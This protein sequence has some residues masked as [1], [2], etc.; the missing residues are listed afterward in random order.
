M[1]LFV[2]A[3][4]T[5]VLA[6]NLV[7]LYVGWEGVGLCSFLL[8]G[9]WYR[10]P[11]T[12]RAARKAFVV[13]R[14]GDAALV[15][16]L[17]LLFASLG[18]LDIVALTFAAGT[19][20]TAGEALP[21]AAAAL[22]LAGAVGKSAQLPLQVWLPDAMAGP[23][24]VSAL[25]HAA[26]MVTAGVY[27]IARMHGLFEL[28]PPVQAAVAIIG[29]LTLLLAAMSALAQTDLKRILAFST[30][31]QIGYMVMALG[32]GAYGAAVFHLTTHAYFKALLFLAAGVVIRR[33]HEEHD[34]R[35]MGG[36]AGALPATFACFAVG[37]AS[38]AALPLVTAGAYSK[39]LILAQVWGASGGAFLWLAGAVGAFLTALYIFRAVFLV[40]LGPQQMAPAGTTPAV[41]LAPMAVLAALAIFGG[42]I[43]VPA[44]V[45]G[46]LPAAEGHAPWPFAAI[47]AALPLAGIYVAWI[48]FHRRRG[49]LAELREAPATARLLGVW[50]VGFGFDQLYNKVA[51]RPFLWAARVNRGDAADRIATGAAALGTAGNRALAWTQSGRLRWYAGAL[52]CGM[53]LVLIAGVFA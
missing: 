26:T 21:V 15:L 34:I 29:A 20:W 37:A 31:S 50:Q 12:A 32:A 52:A 19:Q 23:S 48:V 17:V 42:T 11:G 6:D 30:I 45:A 49:A 22:L 44:F 5:L 2:A 27:L 3:M 39:E 46:A 36:L 40:F 43:P 10:D 47:A 9:F 38:L 4:L 33:L 35:K 7:L 16:G 41:M 8:I 51:A 13:T 28:A 24:P 25:I 1:N 14:V 18:T 53:A